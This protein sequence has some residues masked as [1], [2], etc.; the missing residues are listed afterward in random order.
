MSEE[1]NIKMEIKKNNTFKT[2]FKPQ[3]K[4]FWVVQF[5]CVILF[6]FVIYIDNYTNLLYSSK[7]GLKQLASNKIF[8]YIL[9]VLG[10]Y[11]LIQVFSQDI[12]IP[13]GNLQMKLT[14]HPIFKLILLFSTGFSL[15]GDRSESLIATILYFY[16][17]NILS[18][19][20]V[21]TSTWK[22]A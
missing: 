1:N 3:Y 10:A 19:D 11:G 17:R 12:G 7:L 22:K 15:T 2:Y 18:T 13:T 5:I 21:E 8:N 9:K 16:L 4:F 14:H 20:L 6:I